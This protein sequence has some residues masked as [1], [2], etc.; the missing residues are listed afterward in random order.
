MKPAPQPHSKISPTAKLSAYWRSLS[1]IPFAKEIAGEL[2]AAQVASEMLGDAREGMTAFSPLI[3][4]ARFKAI[5]QGL[6]RSK[7]QHVLE[8]ACGLSSRGLAWVS[9]GHGYTGTDL[10]GILAEVQPVLLRIAAAHAL[11][12]QHLHFHAAN[13]LHKEAL[14]EAMGHC[15]NGKTGVC[16][17]GLLMYLDREEKATMATHLRTLL[18]LPGVDEKKQVSCLLEQVSQRVGRDIGGNDFADEQEAQ[19]FYRELG[20]LVEQYPFYD[21]TYP[22]STLPAVPEPVRQAVLPVLSQAYVWI[23]TPQHRS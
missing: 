22:L 3:M 4:E 7:V 16:N 20:F 19:R 14:Q 15:T 10:P 23:L 12:V 8:L 18:A 21:R 1:S 9:S 11:P 5:D 2:G 13:V 6:K 17:E